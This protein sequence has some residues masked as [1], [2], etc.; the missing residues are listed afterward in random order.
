MVHDDP[1]AL[2]QL[3]AAFQAEHTER[4]NAI[5]HL[6]N[7]LN[8]ANAAGRA[9]VLAAL[10]RE[11]H[12]LKGAARAVEHEPI[13]RWA[14]SFEAA[15]LDIGQSG[16]AP[17][18]AWIDGARTVVA[19]FAQLGDSDSDTPRVRFPDILT[20]AGAAPRSSLVAEVPAAVDV[21]R[22]AIGAAGGLEPPS[23]MSAPAQASAQTADS[24]RVSVGKL[25]TLLAQA[26]ELAVTHIRVARRLAELREARDSTNDTR[27]HWRQCRTLRANIRRKMVSE[28]QGAHTAARDIEALLLFTEQ[29]EER[30]LAMSRRI[31]ELSARLQNDVSQLALVSQGI[32]TDVLAIRLLPAATVLSPLERVVRDLAR[33]QDKA[34]RLVLA[35]QDIEI[36]RKILEQLRDPLM[37]MVR[38]AVDHGIEAPDERE[39]RG[40]P[41]QGTIGL[42]VSQRGGAVEIVIED[43]GAGIDPERIRRSAVKKGFLS[44]ELARNL[45]DQAAVEMI[46][47]AGFSTRTTVTEVSGRGVGMDVVRDHLERLG[48]QIT[49]WS[50]PGQGSRFTI[51]VPLTLATTRAIL[52]EQDGRLYAIPSALIERTSRVLEQDIVSLDGRRAVAVEGRPVPIVELREVLELPVA[53][54][55]TPDA[56]RWRSFFVL[57]QDEARVALLTDQ[58]VGEQEIVV[59]RLA[60]PLRRVRNVGGAAVLGSGQTIAILNPSDVLKTAL[61]I[62]G[63]HGRRAGSEAPAAASAPR[64]RCVLV[65][66]DSLPTRTLERSILETAGYRTLAAGDGIEALKILRGEEIDLIVSDVEMPGLDGFGLTTEIRRDEK[67]RQIPVILVTSLAAPEHQERGVAAGAD[68]YILKGKFDQGQ[69]LDTVGRLI[70]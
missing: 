40:K 50:V 63:V 28:S 67:L 70:A 17:S 1:H 41:R 15:L 61:K 44:E 2:R 66:D 38:N 4:V 47:R 69:L 30:S 6:V 45:D 12:S 24:V 51:R 53:A 39:A 46:F 34:I 68:A 33:S 55:R 9:D 43:D 3:I 29:A 57:R 62:G 26:G 65:V 32:E 23:T 21:R 64:Q 7:N 42:S 54:A 36:D 10:V 60:W 13:E 56:S 59:K 48:G 8:V 19:V 11:T 49:P 20:S 27:R 5:E 25:D 58:L 31:E 52:V 18:P 22:A 35:G 16:A 14:H 37:H